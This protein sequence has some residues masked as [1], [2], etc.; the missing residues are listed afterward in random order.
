MDPALAR[1]FQ[2]LHHPLGKD[3]AISGMLKL[4]ARACGDF[5]TNVV[6]EGIRQ[7]IHKLW[8]HFGMIFRGENVVANFIRPNGAKT[9]APQCNGIFGQLNDLLR[10]T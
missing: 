7:I 9:A 4:F 10:D 6:F 8:R 2:K 1:H 5:G 3:F